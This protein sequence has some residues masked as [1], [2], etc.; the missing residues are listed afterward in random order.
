[1]HAAKGWM[2]WESHLAIT[3]EASVEDQGIGMC[4]S[5]SY[6]NIRTEHVLPNAVQH[7]GQVPL[8]TQS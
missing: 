6:R 2:M 5:V 4:V 8:V 3:L 7:A 1:M